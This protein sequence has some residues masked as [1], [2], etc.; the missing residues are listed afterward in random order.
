MKRMVIVLLAVVAMVLVLVV[1]PVAAR[2]STVEEHPSA[3]TEGSEA[4]GATETTREETV[5]EPTV[6]ETYASYE[7]SEESAEV[8]DQLVDVPVCD[9]AGVG[10]YS[11][12]I[13]PDES[14]DYEYTDATYEES[15]NDVASYYD[16][17]NG[18][19]YSDYDLDL[20][21][22]L[23]YVE[24]GCE[25]MPDWVQLYTGSVVLN[26]VNSPLYADTIEGV[27]YEPGQYVPS[28]LYYNTPDARTYENARMLLEGGSILPAEVMG[29]NGFNAGDGTYATYYDEVLG[30][31]EYFTYVYG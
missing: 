22:R 4:V 11:A 8:G 10:S 5:V 3:S 7:S 18:Y 16:D 14:Y 1:A 9:D 24:N 15:A 2:S 13:V 12:D 27:I 25:W 28:A 6:A 30:S 21:A 20:L 23:I 17:T 29:Q 31:T 19:S 26:R